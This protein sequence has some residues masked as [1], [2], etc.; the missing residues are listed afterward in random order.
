MTDFKE[1][2]SGEKGVFLYLQKKLEKIS[3]LEA[4]F[5]ISEV[6][7][8][9]EGL[10]TGLS[11]TRIFE[12]LVAISEPTEIDDIA[13]QGC[14][15]RD[16]KE[17]LCFVIPNVDIF[18]EIRFGEMQYSDM[19]NMVEIFG[20]KFADKDNTEFEKLFFS[21]KDREKFENFL[22]RKIDNTLLDYDKEKKCLIHLLSQQTTPLKS[23]DQELFC[24]IVFSQPPRH[25]FTLAEVNE[26]IE[27]KIDPYETLRGICKRV[28]KIIEDKFDLQKTINVSRMKVYRN[29]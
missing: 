10:T 13:K 5:A 4:N 9:K 26:M 24:E 2:F 25:E 27:R 21:W 8:R 28:N 15:E 16:H 23:R 7:F 1:M 20:E 18:W 22:K 29:F 14:L 17:P 3:Q 11:L 6:Q 19:G 12:T